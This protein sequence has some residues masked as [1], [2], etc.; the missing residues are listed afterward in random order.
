MEDMEKIKKSQ[1]DKLLEKKKKIEDTNKNISLQ[2]KI[3]DF[4]LQQHKMK[5]LQFNYNYNFGYNMYYNNYNNLY[6]N[7]V[8]GFNYYNY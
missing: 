3:N 8:Y 4:N 7:N 5:L 1:I 6:N 2:Y